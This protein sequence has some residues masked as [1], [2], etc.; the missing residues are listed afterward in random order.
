MKIPSYRKFRLCFGNTHGGEPQHSARE[1]GWVFWPGER[2]QSLSEA[3][4]VG[5]AIYDMREAP[6]NQSS[7]AAREIQAIRG[8]RINFSCVRF[9]QIFMTTDAKICPA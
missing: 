4:E 1:W 8:W 6:G 5:H 7:G 9:F 3:L 2:S